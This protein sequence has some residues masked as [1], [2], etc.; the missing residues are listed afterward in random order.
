LHGELRDLIESVLAQGVGEY[1]NPL[2]QHHE[3]LHDPGELPQARVLAERLLETAE[4]GGR[5]LL[6]QAGG[7][8]GL[9]R[10][11]LQ[12]VRPDLKSHY[13]EPSEEAAP[14]DL[15]LPLDATSERL[16]LVPLFKA[17][18]YLEGQQYHRLFADYVVFDTETT[19]LDTSACEVIELAAVK[20]RGG[21]VVDT[22]HTLVRCERPIS[23]GAPA[24]PRYTHAAPF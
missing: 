10:I 22:F 18:Q 21:A 7:V 20:V 3:R 1:E 16:P 9:G 11:M 17:L 2:E 6:P 19:D 5:V 24:G 15:L 23:A 14:D 4:R 8:E 13:P 12:R